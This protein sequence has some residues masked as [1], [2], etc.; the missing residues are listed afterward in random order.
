M[1]TGDRSL[2]REATFTE[3][4][5]YGYLYVGM[6]IDPP[7][8]LPFVRESAA[9]AE[10]LQKCT[11]VARR[12]N[13]LAEVI[14]VVVYEAVLIP[15]AKHG[16]RFDVMVLIRTTS[17]ETITAVEA[18]EAYRE[19]DADFVMAARNSRRIGDI[20]RSGTGAF[21]FNHFTATDAGRALRTWED[22]AGWFTDK[23]AIDDSALLQPVRA[24]PYVFVNH[25]RLP[26]SPIRFSLRLLK[27]SFRRSV[28]KRL[29]ANGMGFAAVLCRPV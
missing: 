27:P 21:L 28:S 6:R 17:P 25:V 20:D 18:A 3:P 24:A 14:S 29:G 7:R 15:P 13:T 9:R 1:T 26:G 19:L 11:S 10:V 23:A 12:L 22:I 4:A 5:P 8:R 16:P 2:H